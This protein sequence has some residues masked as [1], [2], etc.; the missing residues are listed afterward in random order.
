MAFNSKGT[1]EERPD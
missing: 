1:K